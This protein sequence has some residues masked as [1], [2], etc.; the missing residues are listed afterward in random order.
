M[1][2]GPASRLPPRFER[3]RRQA[4]LG[5]QFDLLRYHRLRARVARYFGRGSAS[6]EKSIP[7]SLVLAS[8]A[9]VT[10]TRFLSGEPINRYVASL[11]PGSCG[12]CDALQCSA[13]DHDPSNMVCCEPGGGSTVVVTFRKR[14]DVLESLLIEAVGLFENLRRS[15]STKAGHGKESGV[16][17]G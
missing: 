2:S 7:S 5:L 6:F 9:G 10:S 4:I 15:M 1:G 11:P 16:C 12:R 17:L 8:Y 13:R 14:P 3:T